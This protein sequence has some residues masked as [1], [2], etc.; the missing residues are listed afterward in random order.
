MEVDSKG[1]NHIHQP[2]PVTLAGV[3]SMA[4][5]HSWHRCNN[6][7]LYCYSWAWDKFKQA[8][9]RVHRLNSEFPI[10]VYVVFCDGTIDQRLESL[11]DEKG[12]SQELVLDGRLMGESAEEV[13]YA[14]LLA[15]AQS[16]FNPADSTVDEGSLL[17]EWPAL[18]AALGRAQAAWD[19]GITMPRADTLSAS[20]T[21]HE[22]RSGSRISGNLHVAGP[23]SQRDGIGCS[24]SEP[25]APSWLTSPIISVAPQP[26]AQTTIP[27]A[28]SAQVC[29]TDVRLSRF[30][31]RATRLAARL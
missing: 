10:N 22:P 30:R 7:I 3:D 11:T 17:A 8:L 9:D 4:E 1:R 29:S 26:M 24:S 19:V 27:E 13:N 6:V 20:N 23:V 18:K 15:L 28:L 2:I 31:I 16:A 12:D 25:A 14:E 21:E 5:G